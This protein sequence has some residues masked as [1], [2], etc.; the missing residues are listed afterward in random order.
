VDGEWFEKFLFWGD[1]MNETSVVGVDFDALLR[2]TSA[3]ID[4]DGF[5]A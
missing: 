5:P 4:V 2:L 3:G 1:L